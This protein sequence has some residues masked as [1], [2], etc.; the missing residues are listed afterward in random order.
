[1]TT[2]WR[3][4]SVDG[5]LHTVSFTLT[6][7]ALRQGVP[8]AEGRDIE[9]MIEG[10]GFVVVDLAAAAIVSGELATS[11]EASIFDGDEIVAT[12]SNRIGTISSS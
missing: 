5:E 11:L 8:A 3:L 6:E 7:S 1:V 4:D 10:E 2:S 9:G 12:T